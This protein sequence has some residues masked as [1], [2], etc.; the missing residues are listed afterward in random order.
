MNIGDRISAAGCVERVPLWK[1]PDIPGW[2]VASRRRKVR[3]EHAV[4]S[5]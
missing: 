1:A 5:S 3:S 2:P 4:E